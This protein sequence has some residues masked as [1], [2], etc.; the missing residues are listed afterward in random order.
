MRQNVFFDGSPH[1]G[2]FVPVIVG[3]NGKMSPSAGGRST[4]DAIGQRASH[5]MHS[6]CRCGFGCAAHSL[7]HRQT[8]GTF[9]PL[10]CV[11]PSPQ[12]GHIASIVMRVN[13][14]IV[15]GSSK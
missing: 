2:H 4:A 9:G 14:C 15:H 3:T 7:P 6:T 1:L 5:D 12:C 10:F 13:G 11:P 8:R